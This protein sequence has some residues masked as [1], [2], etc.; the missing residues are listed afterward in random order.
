MQR[1]HYDIAGD[2]FVPS[3]GVTLASLGVPP[4]SPPA[5]DWEDD[6]FGL[7]ATRFGGMPPA[8]SGGAAPGGISFADMVRTISPQLSRSLARGQSRA[9]LDSRRSSRDFGPVVRRPGQDD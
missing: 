3:E 5:E 1:A 7:E 2:Y 9:V 6:E 8:A 4:Y